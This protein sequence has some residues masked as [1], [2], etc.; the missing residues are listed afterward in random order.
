M[1][2]ILRW[3][4]FIILLFFA[5]SLYSQSDYINRYKSL[6]HYWSDYIMADTYPIIVFKYKQNDKV[7][8][9]I[10]D[11]PYIGPKYKLKIE[12]QVSDTISYI[13]QDGLFLADSTMN[14]DNIVEADE[15]L[16][17]I[18][19]QLGIYIL[20]NHC[21]ELSK[22][23]EMTS[24]AATYLVYLCWINDIVIHIPHVYRYL[25]DVHYW[26]FDFPQKK[27]KNCFY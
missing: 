24:S 8:Y 13:C 20:I 27:L 3:S 2:K 23:G 16:C 5:I 1:K 19:T 17:K 4:F 12:N 10:E 26:D 7:F 22:K 21:I 14:F 15:T 9:A 18:Y 11:Y 6:C 25:R